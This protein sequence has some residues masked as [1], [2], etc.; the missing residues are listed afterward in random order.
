MPYNI[1]CHIARNARYNGHL[2]PLR[3]AHDAEHSSAKRSSGE[4]GRFGQATH[5]SLVAQGFSDQRQ[6]RANLLLRGAAW[7]A[8]L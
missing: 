3:W 5:V 8:S 7:A 2:K 4:S 6:T 1:A